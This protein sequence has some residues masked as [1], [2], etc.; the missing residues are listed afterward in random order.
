MKT[1]IKNLVAATLAM[2]SLGTSAFAAGPVQDK[3]V[4]VLNQVQHMKKIEVN[5]NVE[6]ILVQAPVESVKVYDNYYS[7][8]A[9][10]QEENGVLRIS[11]FRKQ[12]LTVAVYVRD[13]SAIEASGNAKIKTSGKVN[14]LS[15]AIT[16]K[17]NASADIDA[18]TVEMYTA[19]EDNAS[20]NLAGNA[21]S[22]YALLGSQGKLSMDQFNAQSSTTKAM[23]PVFTQAAVLKVKIPALP[24]GD[25]QEE[26]SR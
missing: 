6:V 9:L 23:A 3:N 8:N 17:G 21:S 26:G 14:F 7:K 4:T 1:S 15:L 16:L 24:A 13:L 25:E 18:N 5:G 11:S 22:H 2:I 12:T 20:L 10:V 19:V